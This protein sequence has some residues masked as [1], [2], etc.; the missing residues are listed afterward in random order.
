MTTHYLPYAITEAYCM[1]YAATILFRLNSS[2]GT[3]HEVFELRNMIFSYFGM[4]ATDIFWAL[5]EDGILYIPPMINAVVNGMTLLSISLGCYFWFRFVEDRLSPPYMNRRHHETVIRIPIAILC[6]LDAAS[7]FTGWI[8]TIDA[9]NHYTTGPLFLIQA[10]I[11]YAYL[12]I[13]TINSLIR[14]FR[15]RSRL[16]RTEYGTY[17]VYMIAPLSAGL[18]EDTVPTVP[19]LALNIFMVI[20][21]LFLTIQNMQIYHDALTDLNNR[22]RLDQYL[23]ER[24]PKASAAHPVML[25]MIDINRFKAIN[26]GFGHIE[27]D[28]ALKT[29]SAVLRKAAEKYGAFIAR[30]G[31]DEFC[32][33]TEKTDGGL[34]E[35]EEDIREMLRDEQT[36]GNGKYLLTVSIGCAVCGAPENDAGGFLARADGA[37]YAEKKEWHRKND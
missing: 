18:L 10:V 5:S 22:R 14:F 1:I 17:A 4:L 23:E 32:L 25:L 30:Y 3:E 16:Q 31:G 21:L 35:L 2:I 37:L 8:F 34:E 19:I 12:L 29:V 26:D 20:H 33:V 6:A 15:T 28:K 11:N 27:G 7:I 9:G 24:L 13:P 36:G